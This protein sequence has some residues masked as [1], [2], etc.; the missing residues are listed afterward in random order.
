MNS[1]DNLNIIMQN[2]PRN[3]KSQRLNY[4]DNEDTE[5]LERLH[6]ISHL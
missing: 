2:E 5:V 3:P 1:F 6:L 4:S